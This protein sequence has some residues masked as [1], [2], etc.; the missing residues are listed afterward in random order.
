MPTCAPPSQITGDNPEG[1]R[2]LDNFIDPEKTYPVIATTSKLM[3]TGVDAQTRKLIVLDQSIR[4]M[5]LF[6]QIGRGK[7]YTSL[8]QFLSAW[9]AAQRKAA[10]LEELKRQG[11]LMEA[12]VAETGAE[13]DPFDLLLH[14]AWN[15]PPS[16]AASARCV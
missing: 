15:I 9:S 8:D 10:L 5:T 13:L 3:S 2:E 6:K 16:P 4:S 14:L 1:K 7:Q 12:L 11:V